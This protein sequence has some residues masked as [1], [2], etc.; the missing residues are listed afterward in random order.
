MFLE[1]RK[2]FGAAMNFLYA[3]FHVDMLPLEMLTLGLYFSGFQKF[4]IAYCLL[5][6][7]MFVKN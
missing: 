1:I 2:N 5:R 6:H 3:G 4:A 7:I